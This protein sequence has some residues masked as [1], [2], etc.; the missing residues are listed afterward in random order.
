MNISR[1]KLLAVA[2]ASAVPVR[3]AA[4]AVAVRKRDM[5][6]RSTRPEDLEMPLDGF[7]ELITPVERFF[8]R[9]HHYVPTIDLSSWQLQLDGEVRTPLS[10][11]LA[12]IERMP[13]VELTSVLECAGNGRGLFE[14]AVPGIQ[15]EY[16][17][18]G[19][20]KWTGVR[21]RDI[22][23]RAGV[24][25]SAQHLLFSGADAPPGTMPKFERTIPVEKALDAN[26][27]L[28]YE[29]NGRPLPVQHGF[30]LRLVNPGWAG[31]SW[32]K[33]VT[34]IR[35]LDREFDGFFMKTAY[36]HPEKAVPPGTAVDP[37]K[38]VP[39]TNLAVKSVIHT[40]LPGSEVRSGTSL[41]IAGVAWASGPVTTVDVSADGGKTW[42]AATLGDAPGEFSWRPWSFTAP[43]PSP[44]N[45]AIMARA[46]SASGEEQ[47]AEQPWNPSGYLWNT[48]QRID[49]S[50]VDREPV[51]SYFAGDRYAIYPAGY[52]E[53]CHVC[54]GEDIIEGQ[55]LTRAQWEREVDKMTRWGAPVNAGQR[56]SIL[57]YLIRNFGPRPRK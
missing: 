6:V 56:E 21:L 52:K 41:R 48:V 22:L 38:M 23:Q 19:N 14:P 50:A 28:V 36:R 13:R 34:H 12:E 24:K 42:N 18:V 8:V 10:L 27:L 17:S 5:I 55:R 2:A 44:G 29:M 37:A 3:P 15:W 4:T 53:S 35:A 51:V 45:Y 1:R 9:S 49:V 16:G 57:E 11:S 39:V 46:R 32:V 47:P 26:T 20:A 43:P 31:D 54:H 40:P 33:W 7:R 25:G 30:P